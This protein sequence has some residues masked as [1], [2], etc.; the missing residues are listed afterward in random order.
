MDEP[1]PVTRNILVAQVFLDIIR[2]VEQLADDE[3][4][5]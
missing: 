5:G 3:G 4:G 2:A 1:S